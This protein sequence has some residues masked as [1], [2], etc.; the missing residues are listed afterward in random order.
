MRVEG[1]PVGQRA[2]EGAG[3]KEQSALLQTARTLDPA[4]PF[5]GHRQQVGRFVGIV[6]V[7]YALADTPRP[8][9]LQHQGAG[10]PLIRLLGFYKFNPS[11]AAIPGGRLRKAEACSG[12]RRSKVPA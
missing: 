3:G 7:G 8:F 2:L 10:E 6:R 5:L 1:E 12:F 11:V 4:H 9:G